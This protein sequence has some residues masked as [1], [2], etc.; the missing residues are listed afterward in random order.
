MLISDINTTHS[1]YFHSWP[2]LFPLKCEMKA[3]L[4]ARWND[5]TTFEI[6]QNKSERFIKKYPVTDKLNNFLI[7]N[8]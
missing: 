7:S 1:S 4:V 2:L 3:Y 8:L 5:K 6:L